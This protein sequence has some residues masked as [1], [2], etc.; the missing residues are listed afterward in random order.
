MTI[1]ILAP[2]N[3]RNRNSVSV[4]NSKFSSVCNENFAS[5]CHHTVLKTE[6]LPSLEP[7][8]SW[9][10]KLFLSFSFLLLL[11]FSALL[12]ETTIKIYNFDKSIKHLSSCK[13]MN[14]YSKLPKYKK[15][16]LIHLSIVTIS[17]N[18]F[19]PQ[20]KLNYLKGLTLI[21]VQQIKCKHI[22]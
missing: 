2:S 20:I 13:L 22:F 12:V 11:G 10:F 14:V 16:L 15:K 21:V 18:Y 1:G 4:R 17:Q 6:S 7:P 9:L 3:L 5:A 19:A 8:P